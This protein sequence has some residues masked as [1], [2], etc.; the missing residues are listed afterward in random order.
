MPEY[1]HTLLAT[2]GGQPQVVTF[3]LDLLLQR[4]VPINEV[5]VIHPEASRP[6]LQHSLA[7]LNAEFTGDRYR[8]DG[9]TIHLRSHV[10]RIDGAT[11]DDIVDDASAMGTLNTIHRLI[12]D[13]K[14]QNRCIHLSVTGGR[15]L[16]SLLA[17]SAA[18]LHFDH[19]DRIWH[20]YTPDAVRT[21]AK[22]G[23]LMHVSAKDGVQLIQGPFVPWGTYFPTLPDASAETQR[24]LQIKQMDTQKYARCA[25]VL[26]QATEREREVLRAFA[27]D[28]NPQEVAQLLNISTKT[29]DTYKTKLLGLCRNAW[30]IDPGTR[31]D[32]HF[33]RKTFAPY[34]NSD[35]YTSSQ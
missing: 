13:L 6:R 16:M 12:R 32:Y 26:K 35:E 11:I 22:E 4:N 3:T 19:L 18:Q 23:S 14:L 34:F 8:L 5:I 2:L 10:L 1:M 27:Q 7:C 25:S 29:I 20:I 28:R 15:R 30:A 33:L 31:L 24:S 21:Q 9:R 17:I